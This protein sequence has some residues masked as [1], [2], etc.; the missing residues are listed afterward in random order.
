MKNTFYFISFIFLLSLGA[1][2]EEAKE[3]TLQLDYT[4]TKALYTLYKYD[5]PADGCDWHFFIY[6]QS[7]P[8]LLVEDE[9]SRAKT[10]PLKKEAQKAQQLP[11]VNVQLTYKL[12]GRTQKVQ[13]GWNQMVDMKEINIIKVEI[14]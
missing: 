2:T 10:E 7:N 4:T 8:L 14:K 9:A 12:T 5:L 11:Y 6:D 1:C 3:S 13:C